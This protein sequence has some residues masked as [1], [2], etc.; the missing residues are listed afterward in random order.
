LEKDGMKFRW[1][2]GKKLGNGNYLNIIGIK[3][4]IIGIMEN[5]K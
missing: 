5:K 4:N 3:K 2:E 1:E